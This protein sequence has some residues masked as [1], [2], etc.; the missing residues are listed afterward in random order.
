VFLIDAQSGKIVAMQV[1]SKSCLKCSR[2]VKKGTAEENVPEHQCPK[3]CNGS[4]KGMEAAAAL[5][6]VKRLHEHE[7][8]QVCAKEM[9]LDDDASTRALLTHC[10]KELADFVLGF[11]WPKDSAGKR[12]R[13]DVGK[14]PVDHPVVFFCGFDARNPVFWQTCL[15][16]GPGTP[17]NFKLHDGGCVSVKKKLWVLDA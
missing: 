16:F 11:E 13:K 3:N 17:I 4:S 7:E 15:R 5:E 2:A 1:C 12:I 10:L 9:V 6:M 8:V 14:L